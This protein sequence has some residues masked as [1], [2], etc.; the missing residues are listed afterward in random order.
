[1]RVL[2]ADDHALVREAVASYL[3]ERE[4]FEILHAST[5]QETLDSLSQDEAVDVVL[6]DLVMPGMDGM[7]SI[8]KV[9][10]QCG[11]ARLV[12]FSGS[13]N[14]SFVAQA[15]ELG[16]RG[17]VP[18]TMSLRSIGSALRM[19]RDGE[20]FVPSAMFTD[21]F[22]VGARSAPRDGAQFSPIEAQVLKLAADGKT[23]KEIA[24][25][26]QTTEVLVKMHMR[27]ICK[28]V[29]ARNRTHAAMRAR[30]LGRL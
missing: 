11:K 1:M 21:T 17:F 24:V 9:L 12:I 2:M 8:Q 19:V 3:S 4:G 28:K 15:I 16:V 6:L 18:K 27:S 30:E 14:H 25:L 7:T 20:V 29:D 13:T 10:A 26:L 23:N 5:L 22:N